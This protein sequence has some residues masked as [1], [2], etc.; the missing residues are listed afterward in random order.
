MPGDVGGHWAETVQ[1]RGI[2]VK[3]GQG[4]QPDDELDHTTPRSRRDGDFFSFQQIEQG[5]G[6]KL[7]DGRCR[8]GHSARL[9]NRGDPLESGLGALRR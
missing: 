3:P 6:A 4:F 1:G 5:V 7:V 8:A 2:F 9:G